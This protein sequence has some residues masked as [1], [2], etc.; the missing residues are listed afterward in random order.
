MAI[1]RKRVKS[2]R[3][4]TEDPIY[5]NKSYHIDWKIVGKNIARRRRELKM[6]QQNLADITGIPSGKIS[7]FENNTGGKHPNNSQIVI[8]MHALKMDANAVYDGVLELDPLTRTEK[9]LN[10]LVKNI[11]AEIT[12]S[13]LYQSALEN[14]KRHIPKPL[15]VST[16]KYDAPAS[17]VAENNRDNY[18]KTDLNS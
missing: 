6:T 13:E 18:K 3:V 2:E 12:K 8:I 15:T 4:Y 1:F 10:E 7:Q 5:N 16:L 9:H 14:D 11:S 17:K